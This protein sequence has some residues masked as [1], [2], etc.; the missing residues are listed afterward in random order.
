MCKRKLKNIIPKSKRIC[1]DTYTN[2]KLTKEEIQQKKN[3]NLEFVKIIKNMNFYHDINFTNNNK[4]LI[5]D[6]END[7]T[8]N[9]LKNE[10]R[11]N[12]FM[13]KTIDK[14]RK[15]KRRNIYN[16]N[17]DS[18][19]KIKN[20]IKFRYAWLDSTNIS[21]K[22]FQN[23][24]LAL[25]CGKFIF[26]CIIG[27]TFSQRYTISNRKTCI[28]LNTPDK[29]EKELEIFCSKNNLKFHTFE[30]PDE[31]RLIKTTTHP[32]NWS[33]KGKGILTT[34]YKFSKVN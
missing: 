28:K 17:L 14:S 26:P 24:K 27:I 29:F 19:L 13:I 8:R 20:N 10:L 23:L 5:L 31:V 15:K 2:R 30:L 25:K 11:I 34:F 21:I 4:I 7:N 18:Y 22:M 9:I 1:K 16:I 12:D 3:I 32:K 6:C 33:S